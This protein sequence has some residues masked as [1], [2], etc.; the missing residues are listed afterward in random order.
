MAIGI[1]EMFGFHFLENFNYPYIALSITDFWRRWHISLSSWFKEYVY[2]PLGGNRKGK[3]RTLL[4]LFL[5]MFLSGIWHGAGL[6]YIAWGTMHGLCIV[7]ERLIENK[8]WY[9]NIPKFLKWGTTMFIVMLGWQFFRLGDF[10]E[11]IT[12]FKSLFGL[13]P[14]GEVVFTYE[15]FLNKKLIIMLI[16]AVFGATVFDKVLKLQ[17]VEKLK[18]NKFARLLW[19][20]FLIIL[21]NYALCCIANST[22]S[23]FIYFQY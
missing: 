8:K 12:F 7:V 19:Y 15:Y 21:F 1:G 10:G 2:I 9:L 6:A 16:I 5:V 4:N 11:T 17:L 18:S 14:I 23:P 20:I 3:K 22:Y 13:A